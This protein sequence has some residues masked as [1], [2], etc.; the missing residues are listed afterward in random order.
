MIPEIPIAPSY[1]KYEQLG[2]FGTVLLYT[3]VQMCIESGDALVRK[4]GVITL[5]QDAISVDFSGITSV[6][7][8][9]RVTP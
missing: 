9:L 4:E 8:A 1:C 7:E 3:L 5:R 6:D 2:M